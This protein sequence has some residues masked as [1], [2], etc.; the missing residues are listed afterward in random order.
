MEDFIFGTL[1]TDE[2]RIR[3][4]RDILG[5]VTHAQ[6]RLPRDPQPGQPT[7]IFLTLGPS[8]PQGRAWVYWTKDGSDPEGHNGQ[9]SNGYAT[10]LEPI[11]S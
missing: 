1:A 4:L 9:P 3:H 2:S 7:Q 6:K 5:G 8:H 11:T 10:P